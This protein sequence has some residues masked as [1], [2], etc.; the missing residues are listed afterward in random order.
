MTTLGK[1]R[2][3]AF[4]DLFPPPV[5]STEDKRS[6]EQILDKVT[7]C[8]APQNIIEWMCVR[9]YVCASWLIERYMRHSTLAIERL[10]L[11]QR[12]YSTQ[13][14]R[15]RRAATEREHNRVLEQSILF[16]ERLNA[17]IVL[18]TKMRNDALQQ[19]ELYRAGLGQ[20]TKEVTN[21]TIETECKEIS[22]SRLTEVPSI[23]PAQ[24][25]PEHD[26]PTAD[27]SE[28]AQ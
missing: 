18:Q 21:K 16:Q 4:K 28:S 13:R 11:E 1:N 3:N 24:E 6:F 22:E 23:A 5:L 20:L 26:L 19:L 14:A 7:E 27:R 12:E 2:I 25:S 17:L 15:R 9:H 8:V 10:V